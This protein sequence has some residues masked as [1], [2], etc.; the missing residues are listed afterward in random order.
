LS[1]TSDRLLRPISSHVSSITALLSLVAFTAPALAE[2]ER[3]PG[4]YDEAEL[5]FVQT[6]G[7]AEA[8]TFA[9][10]NTLERLWENALFSFHAGALRAE[11]TTFTRFAV[12]TPADFE[13]IE[14]ESSALTAENYYARLR[15]DRDVRADFFW[16]GGAGWERN[17]FAGFS[18]RFTAVGGVGNWWWQG[19][20]GHFR[21][22][23]G[24]AWTQQDDLVDDPSIGDSFLGLQLSWDYL[25]KIGENASYQNLFVVHENL[26]E[27]D[28][29]RG[30]MI[31]SLQVAM[32][33]R[34]AL[35]VSLQLL[36]DN[37][38]ALTAV[39]LHDDEG[40]TGAVVLTEL[41]E[42]DSLFTAALVV[43]F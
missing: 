37:Q 3:E 25:R 36:Y 26:D 35:K 16:F 43:S 30:D 31:Q 42:L 23:Y 34:L 21:T 17:E 8:S 24:L 33:E 2:D 6:G 13:V 7:N 39:P 4:W 1:S 38:P 41:E 10:K 20:A 12:G 28:D 27:T 14:D 22:D 11:S 5:S 9:L 19:D 40:P 15:Y 18:D 29:L 32:T